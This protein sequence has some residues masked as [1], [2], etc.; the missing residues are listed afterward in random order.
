MVV[1]DM[2]IEKLFSEPNLV[3]NSDPDPYECSDP[4]TMLNYLTARGDPRVP[5]P[6]I[7]LN[8]SN[9]GKLS[10]FQRLFAGF[11][12]PLGV[13]QIDLKEID[14]SAEDVIVHK[15]TTA[16][17]GVLVE[18]T[19]LDV[20]G[21]EVGV[22]VR[23]LLDNLN[24][25]AGKT[26]TWRVLLGMLRDGKVFVY[27]GVIE[28]SIVVPRG[29]GGFGFDPVFLPNGTDQTLSQAKPDHVSARAKAVEAFCTGN[30]KAVRDPIT[31]WTGNWQH[32]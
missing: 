31:T 12:Q 19:S 13:T 3:Q 30:I 21:C 10:E 17:E 26:A 29:K 16:G 20:E 24:T 2:V 1:N 9:Q 28:G 5:R 14:S 22:N 4:D 15:A 18:D 27:E 6:E 32:E 25:Q 23:W 11:N 8:T 7:K